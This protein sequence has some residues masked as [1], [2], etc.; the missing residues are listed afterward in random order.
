MKLTKNIKTYYANRTR[1]S[2]GDTNDIVAR[3]EYLEAMIASNPL[4]IQHVN[5]VPH[6]SLNYTPAVIYRFQLNQD[7]PR[8]GS[9][10]ARDIGWDDE[11]E[12]T[13]A[14]TSELV[15]NMSLVY[16][17]LSM[18]P[19][20]KNENCYCLHASDSDRLEIIA[21]Q[22]IAHWVRFK[23]N[24]DLTTSMIKAQA[25]IMDYWQ[26]YSPEQ[27]I[28]DR[29]AGDFEVWNIPATNTP[30]IFFGESAGQG[31]GTSGSSGDIGLAVWDEVEKVYKIIQMECA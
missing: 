28:Q 29:F 7:L 27:F 9:A 26:G 22:H 16:D 15:P 2:A 23:L 24:E 20:L 14:E 4:Q 30:Y 1:P 11:L 5:N 19:G 6:I 3:L 31:G 8:G 10:Y 25:I 21:L 18:F 17:Q 12:T 13:L